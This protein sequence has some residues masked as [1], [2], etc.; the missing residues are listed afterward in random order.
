MVDSRKPGDFTGL[1]QN[2]TENRPDY[3][4]S[5]LTSLLALVDKKCGNIDFADIGAGTGIW[6]RMVESRNLNSITAVEPNDDM[7]SKG[8]DAS[9]NNKI[10]WLKGTAENTTLTD[11]SFDWVSMASSLH[12]TDLNLALKEFHRIL[13]PR[14]RFTA[15]WNPRLI[16]LNPL[17]VEIENHLN[18]LRPG[19]KRVSSGRSGMTQT[20]TTDLWNSQYFEDVIYI[21]G[22][23]DIEM[24]LD[25][26]IGAWKSVN[27]LQVQ[28]GSEGFEKF[29]NFVE[30]RIKGMKTIKATYCC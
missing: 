6:T 17:L 1:A 18:T 30:K 24:S 4:P 16:E 10:K 11:Q 14:G 8:I 5:V 9:E 13:R 21:E 29:I 12:W 27:D 20:L 19:I 23:H 25:R 22:R 15:L 7:R 3:S 28:L 2:Y 26:Y